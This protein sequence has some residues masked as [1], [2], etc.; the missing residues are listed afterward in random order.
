MSEAELVA[1]LRQQPPLVRLMDALGRAPLPEW[2]VGAGIIYQTWWNHRSDLP[3]ATGIV[4]IDLVY[5]DP[6]R[7]S[8]DAEHEIQARLAPLT[9]PL[10][11]DVNNQARVHQ[12]YPAVF[13]KQIPPYSSSRAAIATW[14]TTA[15]SVGLTSRDGQW[16]LYAPFGLDDLLDMI[17]RPNRVLIPQA[18]YEKKTARWSRCWP[19]LTVTPWA[20]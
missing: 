4:D 17:A 15:S 16:Q 12:W 9:A 13:G 20:Q 2:F 18:V 11:L 14:P 19:L 1:V 5:F 7:C 3:L 8:G 6:D 10:P